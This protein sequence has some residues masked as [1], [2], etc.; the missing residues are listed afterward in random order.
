VT[1]AAAN[2]ARFVFPLVAVAVWRVSTA[3]IVWAAGASPLHRLYAWDGN[4][5]RELL[6]DGY[7][8]SDPFAK[9]T[10][11]FPALPWLTRA[12]EVVV[13]SEDAAVVIV[14]TGAALAAVLLVFEVVRVWRGER[15]ARAAVVGLLVFPTSLFLGQF[16]AEGLFVASSAGA[17]LARARD[18]MALAGAL[19]AV[20]AAARIPGVLIVVPL[21]AGYFASHRRLDRRAWWCA[22]P[23]AGLVPI[24]VA[25]AV[26]AGDPLA[27][28]SSQASTGR[29]L[30]VPWAPLWSGLRSILANGPGDW[31]ELP[32][33][34][35]AALALIVVGILVVRDRS[36]PVDAR[37]WTV[38][39]ALVPL[40][41]G[42][43]IGS[44]LY[45]LAAWPAFGFVAVRQHRWPRPVTAVVVVGMAAL[46]V[47]AAWRWGRGGFLG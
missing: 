15:V 23:I 12:V 8:A 17:L 41:S 18:R 14:S 28:V 35:A 7:R 19:G 25:Q 38:A 37:A 27:F 1:P 43:V 21:A 13:R 20:T 44:A 31:L 32:L 24:A 39:M 4:I 47:A 29:S 16:Y 5:Y 40:M 3:V 36:W 11:F 9:P 22:A 34:V 26:Q 45:A 33:H 46:G 10:A 30:S 42:E 2:R 6:R